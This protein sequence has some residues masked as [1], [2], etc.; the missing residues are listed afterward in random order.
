[1][2]GSISLSDAHERVRHFFSISSLRAPIFFMRNGEYSR[3]R[4][5]FPKGVTVFFHSPDGVRIGIF[6]GTCSPKDQFGKN[7]IIDICAQIPKQT[8]EFVPFPDLKQHYASFHPGVIPPPGT[9]KHFL[10]SKTPTHR[11]VVGCK[12]I[13][14]LYTPPNPIVCQTSPSQTSR[15]KY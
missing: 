10:F 14:L 4:L 1:M 15:L 9:K 12:S 3:C 5:G 6:R 13:S 2:P 11:H 8:L 7:S